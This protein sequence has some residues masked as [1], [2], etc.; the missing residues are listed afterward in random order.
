MAQVAK[1]GNA[2]VIY[3][4]DKDCILTSLHTLALIMVCGNQVNRNVPDGGGDLL[5]ILPAGRQSM[6]NDRC[7]RSHMDAVVRSVLMA[8]GDDVLWQSRP[9]QV[10]GAV[11]VGEDSSS[12]R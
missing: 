5:P 9:G 11:W 2:D 6:Q 4:K 10:E 1:M 7:S 8:G 3:S 12:L